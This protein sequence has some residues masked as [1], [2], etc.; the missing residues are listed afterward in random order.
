MI[1]GGP[2]RRLDTEWTRILATGIQSE[3]YADEA[4]SGEVDGPC[5][6][7]HTDEHGDGRIADQWHPHALTSRHHVT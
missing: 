2:L 5:Q 7:E 3:G 6:D 1:A 4:G